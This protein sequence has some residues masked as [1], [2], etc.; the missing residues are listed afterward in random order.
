VSLVLSSPV[1]YEFE[2]LSHAILCHFL[3]SFA[4]FL[5]LA[6][7]DLKGLSDGRVFL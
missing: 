2:G 3:F 4:Q 5:K 6:S 7:Q 1:R